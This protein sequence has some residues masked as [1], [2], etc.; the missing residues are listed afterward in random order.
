MPFTVTRSLPIKGVGNIWDQDHS[1]STIPETAKALC[2]GS[3]YVL[4]ACSGP[5]RY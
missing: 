3:D 1:S 2:Q 4:A 5:T